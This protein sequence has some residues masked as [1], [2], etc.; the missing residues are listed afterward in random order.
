MDNDT[1]VEPLSVKQ[2]LI[3][4][5][6]NPVIWFTATGLVYLAAWYLIEMFSP[7]P[8]VITVNNNVITVDRQTGQVIDRITARPVW[9]LDRIE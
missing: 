1:Q 9:K 4:K 3:D 5:I 7:V 2:Y 8:I 6:I